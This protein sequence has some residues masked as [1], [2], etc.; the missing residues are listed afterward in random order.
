MTGARSLSI[1][2]AEQQIRLIM[3]RYRVYA[4]SMQRGRYA[5]WA[6]RGEQTRQ[7]TA[8]TSHRDATEAR[9]AFITSDILSLFLDAGWS[10]QEIELTAAGTGAPA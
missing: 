4:V 5:V 10:P 3:D 1:A 9:N 7:A 8:P 6:G 2:E